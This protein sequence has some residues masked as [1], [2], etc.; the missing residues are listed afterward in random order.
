MNPLLIVQLT[1]KQSVPL[2]LWCLANVT[3]S[4]GEVSQGSFACNR[5]KGKT[6]ARLVHTVTL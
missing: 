6:Y 2:V 4:S 3:F 5:F 1:L